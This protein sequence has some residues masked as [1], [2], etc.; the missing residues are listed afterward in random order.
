MGILTGAR[1]TVNSY[2][3][4]AVS[5]VYLS[6]SFKPVCTAAE[7]GFCCLEYSIPGVIILD[8]AGIEIPSVT[9]FLLQRLGYFNSGHCI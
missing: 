5:A 9:A 4:I 7:T 8:P 1:T 3:L 2:G 6:D